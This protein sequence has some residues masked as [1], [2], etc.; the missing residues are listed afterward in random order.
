MSLFVLNEYKHQLI[1]KY[2]N[3]LIELL[4][5]F[6][7]LCFRC[8]TQPAACRVR[9]WTHRDRPSQTHGCKKYHVWSGA[10]SCVLG[11]VFWVLC[12]GSC[13]TGCHRGGLLISLQDE[14]WYFIFSVS[15]WKIK[16]SW[17]ETDRTHRE[18]RFRSAAARREQIK[19]LNLTERRALHVDVTHLLRER[20]T[21]C[22][23]RHS[24]R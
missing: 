22:S 10:G 2:I 11:P 7:S 24:E 8:W 4:N 14:N 5:M 21:W 6:C 9:A 12:S 3:Y 16:I 17:Q 18:D 13:W 15:V 23:R 20:V 19:G 1:N